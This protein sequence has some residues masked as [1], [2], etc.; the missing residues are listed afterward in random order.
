MSTPPKHSPAESQ[1][2]DALKLLTAD[3][4]ALLA[5]F[6]DYERTGKGGEPVEKGKQ[7]LRL[8]H[9]LSILCAIKEEIFYPAVAAVLGKDAAAVLE[10]AL[11]AQGSM[12]GQI[13]R[14]EQMQ[15]G[16]HIFDPAMKELGE[17]ARE[18]FKE[19]EDGLF[20][21]L[22]HSGFDLVGTGE[23]LETRRLQLSTAP[24]GTAGIREARRVLGS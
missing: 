21:K 16:D 13:S 12:R 3:H 7:A 9:R 23:K 14:I 19:E 5:M 8:C 11:A 6:R 24:A 20:A 18:H 15:V 17:T 22:R 2:H 1:S 4:A 10:G